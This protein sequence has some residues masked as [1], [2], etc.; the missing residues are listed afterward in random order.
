M[1]HQILA[2]EQRRSAGPS[3]NGDGCL[4]FLGA[5]VVF[6]RDPFY[7][8]HHA[9]VVSE[10]LSPGRAPLITV[11]DHALGIGAEESVKQIV[12]IAGEQSSSQAEKS[13][14]DS[15]KNA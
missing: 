15:R 14:G 6:D 3:P 11:L 9:K 10:P 2:E 8:F 5:G 4:G 12:R 1:V 13:P 7:G